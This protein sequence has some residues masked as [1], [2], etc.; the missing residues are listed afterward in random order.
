L[1]L[2]L[3]IY[4]ISGYLTI[5]GRISSSAHGI[6]QQSDIEYMEHELEGNSTLHGHDTKTK[7]LCVRNR[8]LIWMSGDTI[9]K[10]HIIRGTQ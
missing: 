5:K 10:I 2:S 1:S 9:H 7:T 6:F 4:H 3:N 8:H